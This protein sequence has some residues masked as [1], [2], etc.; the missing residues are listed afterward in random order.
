KKDEAAEDEEEDAKEFAD[1]VGVEE[2]GIG[3]AGGG[4]DG[5]RTN[6][7]E[8]PVAGRGRADGIVPGGNGQAGNAGCSKGKAGKSGDDPAAGG[9]L[10]KEE[11]SGGGENQIG[12][13]DGEKHGHFTLATKRGAHRR[14]EVVERDQKE[15]KH[16][17]RTFAAAS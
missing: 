2:A 4:A 7:V 17:C 8:Q 11:N 10:P 9:H 6:A 12:R 5:M 13:P 15:R 3:A 16:E 14:K 1:N